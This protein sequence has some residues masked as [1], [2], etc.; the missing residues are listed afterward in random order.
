MLCLQN[1]FRYL[2]FHLIGDSGNGD[3]RFWELASRTLYVSPC[4]LLSWGK[5]WYNCDNINIKNHIPFF[6]SA[7]PSYM[8]FITKEASFK[9]FPECNVSF[10]VYKGQ[11]LCKKPTVKT[12]IRTDIIIWRGA[13]SNRLKIMLTYFPLQRVVSGL[14]HG[15]LAPA[16]DNA[17]QP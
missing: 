5:G 17:E 2:S 6:L 9:N 7:L 14:E 8:S 12:D 16:D 4:C 3:A 15:N 11:F 1:S 10:I 13:A